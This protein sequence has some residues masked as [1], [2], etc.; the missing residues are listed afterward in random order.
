MQ[1]VDGS[2]DLDRPAVRLELHFRESVFRFW[3]HIS[4]ESK[5]SFTAVIFV[6]VEALGEADKSATNRH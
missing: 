6:T 4:L 2:F 5:I 3:G 1:Q